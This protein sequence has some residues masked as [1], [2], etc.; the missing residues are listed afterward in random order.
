M[1]RKPG[2]TI[3]ELA[4]RIRQDAVT[5][6][7]PAIKDP[8]D[9]AMRTRFICSVDNEAVLK[10]LFRIKDNELT[11]AKAI[12]VA[13]ETEEAAKVAKETVYGTSNTLSSSVNK[14]Q[15]FRKQSGEN[16]FN[17]RFGNWKEADFPPGTCP[18]CG[19]SDHESKNC[20][21]REAICHFC[22]KMG[23][24]QTVC[25]KKRRGAQPV[26]VISKKHTICTVKIVNSIPQLQQPIRM[27]SKCFIFEVDTGAG[28]NFCSKDV[29]TEL[30]KPT[31]GKAHGHYEV[32]NGQTLPTLGAFKTSVTLEGVKDSR[33]GP[34][35]FI[36]TETPNL[37]LLGRDA[38]VRLGVDIPA[39]MGMMPSMSQ[40]NDNTVKP[41]SDSLKPDMALQQACR[42]LCEEFPDLY[43]AELGCL[44]DFELEVKFKPD[45]Q[46]VFKKPRLVPF[47][48]QD[49][50]NQAYDVGIAKGVWKPVQ[51][52]A[53]GTPVVPIQK[54]GGGYGFTKVDLAGAFNQI[55]LGPESQ[56]RLALSTHRG[57]LLQL[58]LPFGI[59]SAPGY[60]QEIMDQLTSDLN[61]VATFIDDIL[62]SGMTAS[63]HL[64][65][66]RALLQRLQ[67]RGLRCRLEKCS[68]AQPSIE[69]LGYTLS[70]HGIAKGPKVNAVRMM[71]PPTNSAGLRSFLG[72]VQFY[73]KFLPDLATVTEPL[74]NLTRKNVQWKWG[75]EEQSAFQ[76]LKELLSMDMVLAHFDPTLPIGISCDASEVGLGVVLFHRYQDGSERPIANA[77]KTLTETQR[78]YS[79]IQ[80]EAQAIVFALNKF[81]QFLY[82][83]KFILVTDHKP[84]LALF[85]PS[86]ATPALAANRLA[87]WALMLS[88]YDY[89]IEY[90]RTSE[91]GNADA[92]SRL[93]MGPD[94]DFY[95]EEED[96]DVDTVCTIRT[97]SLQLNPTDQGVL[98]NESAKDPVIANVIRY[99]REGWP[100]KASSGEIQR[101][102]SI[103]DFRKLAD[104]LSAAHGNNFDPDMVPRKT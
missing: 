34:L 102:Y 69:Y 88:Q 79:Q 6:D 100:P 49:E 25:L 43:K 98:A 27:G 58:R 93:P 3:Q 82:G 23:H 90:R 41:I 60:F 66:L 32:A 22:Q 37:N 53:H 95:S 54:L 73:S 62:V 94:T 50:L 16:Q 103:E 14:V 29:W 35:E 91:Q 44:K 52:N 78:H 57:V 86:K 99:T 21:F 72:S 65:N 70:S 68:F 5:C 26:R 85:G 75:T 81:H 39:L 84:L 13:V 42:Q 9:E 38:I 71:P 89:S 76:K 61:G 11:F 40:G 80:K 63:E 19:Q 1:R 7:F 64:Q 33:E 101:D 56:K 17:P 55:K 104:S 96:A 83:R 47:A 48:I 8:L 15:G 97:I 12:A 18:R 28:D 2:E 24:L 74:H 51:F 45:V 30:G 36:V 46:P 67:E 77:L 4:A 20:P 31:L 87:R 92:L 59:S 10:A